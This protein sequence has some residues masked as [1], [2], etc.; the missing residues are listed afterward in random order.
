MSLRFSVK[1]EVEKFKILF[2]LIVQFLKPI[3]CYAQTP[4]Q[5]RKGGVGCLDYCEYYHPKI[6]LLMYETFLSSYCALMH[7]GLLDFGTN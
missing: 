1:N 5:R 2:I 6:H 7:I 3:S 4:F